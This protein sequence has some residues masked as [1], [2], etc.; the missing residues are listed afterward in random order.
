MI[1]AVIMRYFVPYRMSD[2]FGNIAQTIADGNYRQLKY[3]NL[4]R[5]DQIVSCSALSQRD[6]LV[7]AEECFVAS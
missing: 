2:M 1:Q 7:Q 3:C 5:Q 4:I 6:T